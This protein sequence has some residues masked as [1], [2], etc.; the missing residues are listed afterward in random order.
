[1]GQDSDDYND[2]FVR[3]VNKLRCNLDI[4]LDGL[5]FRFA[6]FTLPFDCLSTCDCVIVHTVP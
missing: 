6:D 4:I 1:M 2:F 3:I 5:M